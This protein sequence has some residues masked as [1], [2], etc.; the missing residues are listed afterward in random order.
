MDMTDLIGRFTQFLPVWTKDQGIAL[1][2]QD[3]ELGEDL[4]MAL[5]TLYLSLM[6]SDKPAMELPPAILSKTNALFA[7]LMLQILEDIKLDTLVH[8]T[9]GRQEI[10]DSL[11]Q[12]IYIQFELA[13]KE[14]A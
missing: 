9:H 2:P 4:L 10:L 13:A 12:A 14:Q 5:G 11:Y 6:L 8:E 7:P 3:Q 1:S